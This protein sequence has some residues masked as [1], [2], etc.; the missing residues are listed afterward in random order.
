MDFPILIKFNVETFFDKLL[1]HFTF[2]LG[3]GIL[4]TNVH[5]KI[6][7]TFISS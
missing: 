2:N 1:N 6:N 7:T 4:T 3:R 5:N